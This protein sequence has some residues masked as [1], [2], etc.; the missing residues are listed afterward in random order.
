FTRARRSPVCHVARFAPSPEA[1]GNTMREAER[2]ALVGLRALDRRCR[3]RLNASK[4][5]LARCRAR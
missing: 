3:R 1:H 2:E 5:L 4:Y